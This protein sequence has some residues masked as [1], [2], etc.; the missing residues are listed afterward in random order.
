MRDRS[1]STYNPACGPTRLDPVTFVHKRSPCRRSWPASY[2]RRA[3][4]RALPDLARFTGTTRK[5][6][7]RSTNGPIRLARPATYNLMYDFPALYLPNRRRLPTSLVVKAAAPSSTTN[8]GLPNTLVISRRTH[9]G[10]ADLRT[11][12][13]NLKRSL[14]PRAVRTTT[15]RDAHH[16]SPKQRAIRYP[17]IRNIF[18]QGPIPGTKAALVSRLGRRAERKSGRHR[19]RRLLHLGASACP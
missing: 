18:L 19:M 5:W 7:T 10:K 11:R 6:F 12:C 2:S 3:D 14:Q 15:R 9:P 8:L 16:C 4:R 13:P 1:T 17:G